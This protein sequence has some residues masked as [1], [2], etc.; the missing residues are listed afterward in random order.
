MK[1]YQYSDKKNKFSNSG[2]I[3]NESHHSLIRLNDQKEKID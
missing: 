1:I 3:Y 2:K